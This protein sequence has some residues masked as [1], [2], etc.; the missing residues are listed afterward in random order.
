MDKTVQDLLIGDLL[1]IA[2]DAGKNETVEILEFM[3]D[4]SVPLTENQ[5]VAMLMLQENDLTD[6]AN[7]AYNGRRLVAPKRTYFDLISK[8][9]L[10]DRIRGNAKLSHL[11]KANANPANGALSAKDLQAQGMSKKEIDKF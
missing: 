7:F 3:R 4:Y 8:L 5:F 6:I 11:L 9:T 1:H 2:D 10:A